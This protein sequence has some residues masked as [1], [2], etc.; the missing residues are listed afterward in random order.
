MRHNTKKYTYCTRNNEFMWKNIWGFRSLQCRTRWK[1]IIFCAYRIGE[2]RRLLG[3]LVVCIRYLPI[4]CHSGLKNQT[5]TYRKRRGSTNNVVSLPYRNLVIKRSGRDFFG[6]LKSD[7]LSLSKR[8]VWQ[9]ID[10]AFHV[11][12]TVV[13]SAHG[14]WY[15]GRT[16]FS[17]H[18]VSSYEVLPNVSCVIHLQTF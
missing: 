13:Y 10:W 4:I 14:L 17:D 7:I 3:L 5:D 15:S 9:S 16:Q 11:P 1:Q 2:R 18:S 12:C 8:V 6:G